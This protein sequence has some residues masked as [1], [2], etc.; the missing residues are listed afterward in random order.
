MVEGTMPL[1]VLG[2]SMRRQEDFVEPHSASCLGF[3]GWCHA[4]LCFATAADG[5]GAARCFV[6]QL[7]RLVVGWWKG[8]VLDVTSFSQGQ[9]A[10]PLTGLHVSLPS[11]LVILSPSPHYWGIFTDLRCPTRA[12]Q[13]IVFAQLN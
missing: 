13:K 12:V 6:L 5:G 8:Y 3:C 9:V 2:F 10:E 4:L 11:L 7:L 1:C